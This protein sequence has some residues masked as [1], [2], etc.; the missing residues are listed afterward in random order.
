MKISVITV[1]YNGAETIEETIQSVLSQSYG[2]IQYIVIDG[3]STD[4]TIDII[5]KY[6]GKI[7]QVVSEP[8]EGIYDAMNKGIALASGDVVGFLNADDTY[9]NELILQKIANCFNEMQI[10]ACYADLVYVSPTNTNRI[11]RYWRSCDYKLGLFLSGWMPAHPT[12][13]VKKSIYNRFGVF[14]ISYKLQSDFE[15]TM[16]FMHVHKIST[17]YIPEVFVRM[18]YGGASNQSLRNIIRGNIEAYQ[19]T[20]KHNLGLSWFFMVRKIRSRLKQFIARPENKQ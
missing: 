17:I 15:L 10:D 20:K 9:Q 2:D 5:K 7:D 16:R 8:D 19:A 11:L 18:R 14:D 1:V 3:A 6:Q 4:G 13:Y 12:F